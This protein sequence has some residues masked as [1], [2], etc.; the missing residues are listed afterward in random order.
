MFTGT[1]LSA[2]YPAIPVPQATRTSSLRS[3]SSIVLR[4]QTSKSFDTRHLREKQNI[5]VTVTAE[6]YGKVF[7]IENLSRATKKKL[8]S[9]SA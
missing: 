3:I 6:V 4:G 9:L 2:T 1:P 8:N 7:F 5:K